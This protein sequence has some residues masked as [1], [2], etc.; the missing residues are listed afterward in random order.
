VR[1]SLCTRRHSPL[2]VPGL[3]LSFVWSGFSQADGVGGD[4]FAIVWDAQTQKLFGINGSGRSP[5]GLSYGQLEKLGTKTIPKFGVLPINVPGTVDAWFEL[6]HRFGKLPMN[7]DLAPAIQYQRKDL[8]SGIPYE[9]ARD[10]MHRGH[11][12]RFDLGGYGGYQA[13]MRDPQTGVLWSVGEQEGWRC[14]RLLARK[15][16]TVGESTSALP[17]PYLCGQDTVT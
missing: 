15:H 7:E 1:N 16:H 3:L 8:E 6:H 2:L 14:R 11:R 4:L 9:T 10:L 13:I 17:E 5:K 12:V